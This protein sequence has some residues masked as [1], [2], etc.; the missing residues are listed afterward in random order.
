VPVEHSTDTMTRSTPLCER[1]LGRL[2]AVWLTHNGSGYMQT[3]RISLSELT[4][5]EGPEDFQTFVQVPFTQTPFEIKRQELADQVYALRER[6]NR[7][8]GLIETDG[9]KHSMLT[10]QVFDLYL[11]TVTW[12]LVYDKVSDRSLSVRLL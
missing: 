1:T 9:P 2:I 8:L 6:L 7:D 5:S 10:T 11:M 4:P 3:N 12:L